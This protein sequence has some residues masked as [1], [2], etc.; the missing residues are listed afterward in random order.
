MSKHCDTPIIMPLS[1]PTKLSEAEPKDL[2]K[3][4]SG[5]A[6]VATGSPF[7]PVKYKG[8]VIEIA[9]SNNA[10]VFPGLG[11]GVIISKPKKVSNAMIVTAAKTLSSCSPMRKNKDN[12]MLP[13]FNKVEKIQFKIAIAVANQARK[14]G[15]S[16]V[17]DKIDFSKEI[18]NHIWEAKYHKY[19]Y[20]NKKS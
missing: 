7:D 19:V 17:S 4:S 18:Y 10:F 12:P 6:L 16:T 13:N 14:E 5:R 20:V 8:R 1:N 3:W 11:L 9:Q 2:I 15:L